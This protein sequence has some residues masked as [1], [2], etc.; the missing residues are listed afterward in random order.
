MKAGWKPVIDYAAIRSAIVRP[1]SAALGIPVIMGDQTGKM[2]PYPFVTYKMTSP[3]LAPVHGAEG[4]VNV[5]G[6]IRRTQEKQVEVVFSFTVHSKDP[7]EAYRR[8]YALIEHFDFAGRDALR[9]VGI[10]VVN[11]TNVQNRDVFLTIEYERR[12]GCD[13]RFRVL[14]RSELIPDPDAGDFIESAEIQYEG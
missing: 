5:E 14:N 12:V 10:V 11:V 9:D 2:P 4:V 13:V 8:C 1:L 3:Y 6:G 7:D